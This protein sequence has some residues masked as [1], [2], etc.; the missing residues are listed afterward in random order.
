[1]NIL[2]LIIGIVLVILSIFYGYFIY[3]KSKEIDK[4][5]YN[6][7]LENKSLELRHKSLSEEIVFMEMKFKNLV[8]ELNAINQTIDNSFESRKELSKKAFENYCNVLDNNYK[9]KEIEYNESISLLETSYE[10]YQNKLM[11]ETDEIRTSLDSIRATRTAAI[12]AQIKE[13][14]VK[15]KSSFYCLPLNA[16]DKNDIEFINGMKSR[17]SQ[18]RILSMLIWQ[19]YFQK[20]MTTL[21]NNVLGTSVVTGIY[22]ITNQQNDMCYIGQAVDVATRWK[23]HAKCGLGIDTPA[24]NKL[25]KAMLEEGI[26]N[27]SWE[28]IEECPRNELDAK[29]KFY[30]ELYQSKDFGYNTLKGNSN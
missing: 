5:N 17:L 18:P 4:V 12:Q 22:K 11:R 14:E 2:V 27:F 28:L 9:E 25:Y 16:V 6:V 21:C 15:E 29:E 10:N 24:G 1:M 7:A 19:T 30:I 26:W 20:P 13:K 8:D 23:N 3:K